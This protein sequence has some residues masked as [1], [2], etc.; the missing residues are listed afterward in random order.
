MP[1][2]VVWLMHYT[3]YNKQILPISIETAWE[4]FS[5]PVNLAEITPKSMG[6]VVLSEHKLEKVYAGQIIKYH[7]RP[8]LGIRM[9]WMTEITHVKQN[10]YFVDEQRFGPYSLWHHQHFFTPVKGGVLMEDLVHYK[11]PMGLLGVLAH[12]LFVKKQLQGIFSY[13]TKVLEAK[14]GSM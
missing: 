12:K 7:V 8:V 9:F 14:F 10:E 1:D 13:R 11:L 2:V 5:S 4:F 3:L 6:F